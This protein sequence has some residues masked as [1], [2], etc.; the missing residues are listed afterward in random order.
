VRGKTP[1]RTCTGEESAKEKGEK[2][3]KSHP[4]HSIGVGVKKEGKDERGKAY[5]SAAR[6]GKGKK[7]WLSLMPPGRKNGR[8]GG[9]T[10]FSFCS[11]G[12]TTKKGRRGEALLSNPAPTGRKGAQLMPLFVVPR[13]R[14]RKKEIEEDPLRLGGKREKG[15]SCDCRHR[16]A[17]AAHLGEKQ[18]GRDVHSF[19][20]QRAPG[21]EKKKRKKTHTPSAR[22]ER[23]NGPLPAGQEKKKGKK[24]GPL[25]PCHRL[26]GKR[27][28][29]RERENATHN[30]V[31]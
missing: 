20:A 10:F 24:N 1:Q 4:Y 5:Y 30:F 6:G 16:R 2:G 8:E 9:S 17:G 27:E 12:T 3:E 29:K 18:E 31:L 14:D 19:S 26:R 7:T 25:S 15:L 21:K 13:K 23:G 11:K 28:K 22:F